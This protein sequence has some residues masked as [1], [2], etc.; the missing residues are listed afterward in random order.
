[1]QRQYFQTKILAMKTMKN[2]LIV[3]LTLIISLAASSQIP[4]NGNL[5]VKV[6]G[7]ESNE[8]SLRIL[9]FNSESV[10]P[11][12]ERYAFFNIARDLKKDEPS[13]TFNVPFGEYAVVVYHD[14][15]GNGKLD[16]NFFGKPCEVRAF[17]MLSGYCEAPSYSE[18]SFQFSADDM[19]ITISLGQPDVQLSKLRLENN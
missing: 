15:N 4:G 1:M 5:N 10:F 19:T 12:Y 2:F 8:G 11:D 14:K 3:F 16:R 13:E 9:L 17:S 6:K 7:L 18:C